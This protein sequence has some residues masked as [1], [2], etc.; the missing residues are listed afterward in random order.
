MTASATSWSEGRF[1]GGSA[2]LRPESNYVTIDASCESPRA[3]AG[4]PTPDPSASSNGG[5]GAARDD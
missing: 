3:A 5:I 1:D 4:L 2:A